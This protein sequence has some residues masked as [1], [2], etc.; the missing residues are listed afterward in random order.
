MWSLE[1]NI[2]YQWQEWQNEPTFPFDSSHCI[3]GTK[4]VVD[5]LR[6]YGV[7]VEAAQVDVM[8]F[9][10]AGWDC[11]QQLIPVERW[12]KTGWS[13]GVTEG[14]K[15]AFTGD[16]WDGHLVAL[17]ERRVTDISARQFRRPEH[18]IAIDAVTF[19]AVLSYGGWWHVQKDQT[20]A[21]Y[22]RVRSREWRNAPGWKR[23]HTTEVSELIRRIE[24]AA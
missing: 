9:N 7:P 4:V 21:V 13:V 2:V 8:V 19:P 15:M 18:G 5:V 10:Q 14:R 11:Y 12:P 24:A 3:N 1:E 6:H 20:H 17:T 22:R 16:R 23:A